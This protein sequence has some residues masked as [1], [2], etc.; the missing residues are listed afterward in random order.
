VLD[1]PLKMSREDKANA[2]AVKETV[3]TMLS[4]ELQRLES[5]GKFST[6]QTQRE[7]AAILGGQG[8]NNLAKI[9]YHA[10]YH[11]LGLRGQA[12]DDAV[13][14]ASS[15]VWERLFSKLGDRSWEDAGYRNVGGLISTVAYNEMMNIG[16]GLKRNQREQQ[17]SEQERGRAEEQIAAAAEEEDDN[18]Y[19]QLTP[20]AEAMAQLAPEWE[21]T[22][23]HG[24]RPP[25][26]G[27]I[28]TAQLPQAAAL[29]LPNVRWAGKDRRNQG[30]INLNKFVH[31]AALERL[32]QG[33]LSPEDR[34][35]LRSIVDNPRAAAMT[36]FTIRLLRL[37]VEGKDEDAELFADNQNLGGLVQ[38][39]HQSQA[40]EKQRGKMLRWG[41]K[42]MTVGELKQFGR[43]LILQKAF[44]QSRLSRPIVPPSPVFKGFDREGHRSV[45]VLRKLYSRKAPF[46]DDS[47]YSSIEGVNPELG[48]VQ[49]KGSI[50][51]GQGRYIG[52]VRDG[53]AYD[54]FGH[55]VG[56]Y[57]EGRD[58]T[59]DGHGR[60][61][62]RGNQLAALVRE[63]R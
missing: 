51:D 36:A 46:H 30:K 14:E 32:Q 4:G 22:R 49:T 57:D 15:H 10:G 41:T 38:L 11:K 6:P 33:G 35:I 37:L 9:L 40:K 23:S 24:S 34:T 50:T 25:Q 13:L 61:F 18:P 3:N 1:Q 63:A 59:Y 43:R 55:F 60:Y 39:F 52:E 8:K 17:F 44:P 7:V 21:L 27:K 28:G 19:H 54:R 31:T 2:A 62:G 5:E 16:R 45:S 48:E 12:L 53:Q 42:S 20:A 58:S 47:D 26:P 29:V 56:R